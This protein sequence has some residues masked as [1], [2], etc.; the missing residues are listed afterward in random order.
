MGVHEDLPIDPA[1]FD[2][3]IDDR[4]LRADLD[5]VIEL[6]GVLWIHADAAA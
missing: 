1:E 2:W 5:E 3:L 4:D 6:L